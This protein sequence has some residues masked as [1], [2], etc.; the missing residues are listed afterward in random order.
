M[1]LQLIFT[2]VAIFV[3]VKAESELQAEE[4]KEFEEETARDCVHLYDDCI[5]SVC[6]EDYRCK[7]GY[8]GWFHYE[9][10]CLQQGERL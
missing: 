3:L 9:C 8:F 5:R 7:C 4:I 6:C 1:K 2:C 10:Y